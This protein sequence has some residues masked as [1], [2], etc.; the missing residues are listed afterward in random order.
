MARFIFRIVD[1]YQL[2]GRLVLMTD[3]TEYHEHRHGDTIELHRPDGSILRT[4]GWFEFHSFSEPPVKNPTFCIGISN[5][6]TKAD[7]PIGTK[8]WLDVD[9]DKA[10]AAACDATSADAGLTGL[11][12]D[13]QA[14]ENTIDERFDSDNW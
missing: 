3:V 2:K 11:E 12:M 13:W 9:R 1:V 4:E 5:I 8:V 7:V 14:L 10:L 6:Y